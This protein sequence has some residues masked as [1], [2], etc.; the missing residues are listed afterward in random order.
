MKYL[1][2]YH[3][4]TSKRKMKT[5]QDSKKIPINA[6]EEVKKHIEMHKRIAKNYPDQK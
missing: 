2:K 5:I 1:N 3:E 6:E 4:E